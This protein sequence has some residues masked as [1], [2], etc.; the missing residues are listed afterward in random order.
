MSG[1]EASRF[2]VGRISV[3]ALSVDAAMGVIGDLVEAGQGGAVFTADVDHVVL[4]ER[5]E[6]FR[7]A[8][9]RAELRLAEGTGLAWAARVLGGMPPRPLAPSP[10]LSRD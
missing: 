10:R 5:N 4:A 1:L 7:Q 8:C 2:G 3:D 6:P 9:A